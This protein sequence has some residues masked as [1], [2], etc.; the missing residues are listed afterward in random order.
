MRQAL[1]IFAKDVRLYWIEILATLSITALFAWVY[2]MDWGV[3]VQRQ[4]VWPWVPGTITALVPVSWLV[5][6]TRV[7]HAESLVGERQFWITRPY[8]WPVLISS[9]ALFFSVFV[10]LPFFVA[11]CLLLRQ[12]GIHPTA[13]LPGLLFNLLL[14]TGIA[15]LPMACLAAVTG[16]FPRM[17]L[18][19]LCVLLFVAGV[20]YLSDLLPSSSTTNSF[21]DV[22]GFFAPVSVFIAVLVIQYARRWTLL[23]RSLLVALAVTISLLGLFGPED[24][25]MRI[26]YPLSSVA[27]GLQV[28]FRQAPP[29][30]AIPASDSVDERELTVIFPVAISGIA[31]GTAMKIDNARVSISGVNGEH[32]T[33]HWQGMFLTWMPGATNGEVS[34][35]VNRAFYNRTKDKQVTVKMSLALTMMRAGKVTRMALP[36]GRFDL[37]GGSVCRKSGS[38]VEEI[39]CLSPMRQPPLTLV[40]TQ[41]SRQDCS[42]TPPANDGD[43]GL[44]WIGTLDTQPAEFGMTSV[45]GSSVYLQPLSSARES[46]PQHL[47]PGSPLSFTAYTVVSRAQQT[48]VSQPMKLSSLVPSRS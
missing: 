28:G 20:A 47:C 9:K 32:W 40:T 22:L 39:S 27:T 21:G 3:F 45:W 1:H 44:G 13:H 29:I 12:A 15:V 14:T 48:I 36:Q 8:L 19:L 23:S 11:Q 42:D 35:K 6:I 38:W 2:P 34:L 46:G 33:S 31:P 30:E 4:A 10:Y 7:I 16:N 43:R 41:F 26:T 18:G 24:T 5:L 17:L 37:P 25:A